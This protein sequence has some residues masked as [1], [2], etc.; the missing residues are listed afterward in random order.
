MKSLF[1]ALRVIWLRPWTPT[2]LGKTPYFWLLS[3][4]MFGWKYLYVPATAK[5]LSLLALSLLAF[6]PF[7]FYSFWARGWR[8]LV[9]VLVS[10]ALGLTWA[11]WNYGASTFCIFAA[12]M[13]SSMKQTKAAYQSLAL[14]VLSTLLA[15]ILAP[16]ES[17]FWIP[18]LLFSLTTGITS[19]AANNNAR[20]KESLL[21]KQEE[22]EHIATIAERERIARDM[23]DLLGH[24][25]SVISLKAQLAGKLL[26]RDAQACQQEIKH[27]EE[28]ARLA[29]AEVREAIR[30]YRSHGLM[31]EFEQIRQA[32]Q[33]AG[34]QVDADMHYQTL[35][36]LIENSLSLIL[37]EAATN[38]LRHAQASVC[39]ISLHL[40]ASQLHL[41]IHDNGCASQRSL[42]KGSGLTGM[43]ER[44]AA[45]N[46]QLELQIAAGL[47]LEIKLPLPAIP[48]ADTWQ[49]VTQPQTR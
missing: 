34:I 39:R 42:N 35:P 47:R 10:Q 17:Y 38:V 37:R 44:V 45:L 46:G 22:V 14:L 7:Y 31:H 12:S 1:A 19:I 4:A 18:A 43:Y 5:E 30:G 28:T 33:A 11:H 41:V 36:A 6:L 9:C 26:Q 25:L 29:L 20:H 3:F 16:F 2:R 27:I 48:R 23:H 13:C 15:S 8:L 49:A 24:R 40:H 32:L 21:R